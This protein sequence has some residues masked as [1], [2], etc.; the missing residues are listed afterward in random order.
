VTATIFL[1]SAA[2]GNAIAD[3]LCDWFDWGETHIVQ[4]QQSACVSQY[5]F[6]QCGGLLGN[7]AEL[8]T[9]VTVETCI[10]T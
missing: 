10:I 4:V 3:A 2:C 6:F 5:Y 8:V 7:V 9:A 1:A